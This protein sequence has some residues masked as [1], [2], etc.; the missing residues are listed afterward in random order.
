[1]ICQDYNF[2]MELS[3]RPT[4]WIATYAGFATGRVIKYDVD[5]CISDEKYLIADFGW[6]SWPRWRVL[7]VK[8]GVSGEWAGKFTSADAALA[9]VSSV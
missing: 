1:M 6:P 9:F 8:N 7:Q 4:M 5:G 2:T 3:M